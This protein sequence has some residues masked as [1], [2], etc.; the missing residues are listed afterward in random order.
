MDTVLRVA[1]LYIL[2]LAGLR[3]MGKRELSDLSP[4]E[5]VGLLLVSEIASQALTREDSSLTGAI[6]GI[7]TLFTLVFLISF[8]MYRSKRFNNVVEGTPTVIVEHGKL[9]EESLAKERITPDEIFTEMHKS[10][11]EKLSQV[12]WAILE[13]DGKFSII[14]TE[15]E[16]ASGSAK[17][18]DEERAAA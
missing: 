10:G 13:T 4:S 8:L 16:Q 7:A 14:P 3:V 18:K 1:L 9:I 17:K 11:L 15:D 12:K 6:V 2:I 5:L